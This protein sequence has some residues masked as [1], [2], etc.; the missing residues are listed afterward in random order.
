MGSRRITLANRP[1]WV[2]CRSVGELIDSV[3]RRFYDVVIKS[4]AKGL[5]LASHRA[6][7]RE[8]DLGEHPFDH[9]WN[10]SDIERER[11]GC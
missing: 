11:R 2:N 5:K 6:G 8:L 1:S 3:G 4:R 10:S 7:A 9:V